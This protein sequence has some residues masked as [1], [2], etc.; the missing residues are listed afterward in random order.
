MEQ[1]KLGRVKIVAVSMIVL[2]GLLVGWA[3]YFSTK[4]APPAAVVEEVKNVVPV[5][6]IKGSV[7]EALANADPS[8][9]LVKKDS[10][11]GI[12]FRYPAE[13]YL[14]DHRFVNDSAH[15][16]PPQVRILDGE[17]VCKT[18]KLGTQNVSA[19]V[20]DGINFCVITGKEAGMSHL[21]SS[22]VY[23]FNFTP[24]KVIEFSFMVYSTN[25]CAVYDNGVEPNVSY[26]KCLSEQALFTP[27]Y[28]DSIVGKMAKSV[29]MF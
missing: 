2:I 10:V 13:T 6:S 28:L 26:K 5:N 3:Y 22:Y 27:A 24:D 18:G 11:N 29:K 21:W 8:L 25:G 9:W 15:S 20:I 14:E 16:W 17:L 23:A 19:R 7:D 4:N 12:S 1:D